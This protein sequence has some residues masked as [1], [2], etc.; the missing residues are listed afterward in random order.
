LID[1]RLRKLNETDFRDAWPNMKYHVGLDNYVLS[2]LQDEAKWIS[3]QSKVPLSIPDIRKNVRPEF[4]DSAQ[5]LA[6]TISIGKD[7]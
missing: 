5:P 3:E 1:T 6:V 2:L 4:L 7:G